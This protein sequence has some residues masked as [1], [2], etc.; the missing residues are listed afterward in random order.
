[1]LKPF[2]AG[3]FLYFLVRA[4]AFMECGPKTGHAIDFCSGRRCAVLE[5]IDIFLKRHGVFA[6]R[7]ANFFLNN[8]Q[9]LGNNAAHNEIRHSHLVGRDRHLDLNAG[10]EPFCQFL[11]IDH[12][13]P[14]RSGDSRP[15]TR[16][17]SARASAPQS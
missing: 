6:T 8:F 2:P 13:V 15:E 17:I 7:S 11:L 10:H 4:I 3:A 1:M 16:L 9:Y 14:F 5:L 12:F